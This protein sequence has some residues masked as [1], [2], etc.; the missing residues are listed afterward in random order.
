MVTVQFLGAAGTVTGSKFLLS[1]N[2]T[3][4]LIDC[5]L[6]QGVKLLRKLNW[7]PLPVATEDLNAVILTHAHLDHTGY[8][9]KLYQQGFRGPIFCTPPTRELTRLILLDSAKLQE[10]DARL[11]NKL[12]YSKHKPALPLYTQKDA[13]QVLKLFHTLRDRSLYQLTKEISFEFYLAG[14][15]LGAAS[16]LVRLPSLTLLF[17]GDIG[18]QESLLLDP[19]EVPAMTD[20]LVMEGTYGDRHHSHSNT[21]AAL[22]EI[23]QKVWRE[24]GTVLIPAFAVGRTQEL[25][26]LLWRMKTQ[27]LLPDIP[28]YLDSPMAQSATSIF[29]KYYGWHKLSSDTVHQMIEMVQFVKSSSESLQLQKSRHPKIVIAGSGMLEG[30][31]ILQYIKAL[32]NDPHSA[33]VF[34]GYQAEGTRGRQ[35]L[36]GA[37]EIKIH[38]A[39]YPIQLQIYNISELSAHADQRELLEWIGKFRSIPSKIFLVHGELHA[40]DMLRVKIKDHYS[41]E[42]YIPTL[43]ESYTISD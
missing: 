21:E 39:Y 15:I 40:L 41:I 17:S 12:G 18:R 2:G 8:L 23:I 5:G 31:R 43:F 1:Y 38:G 35:L 36:E 4:I 34:V 24:K 13:R 33:L 37:R 9:P 3:Q 28:V 14:H 42:P 30:G 6:F 27:Q 16:V 32:H 11:A 22:Q 20:V 19:P 7:N 26:Y 29:R 10:E 25:L